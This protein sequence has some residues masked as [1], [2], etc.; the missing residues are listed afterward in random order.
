[1]AA[2]EEETQ[3]PSYAGMMAHYHEAFERE[4]REVVATAGV[5]PGERVVDV[6][7]GD[8]SYALWLAEQAGPDGEVLAVD[9]STPFLRVARR[10]IE[11][12]GSAPMSPVRFVQMDLARSPFEDGLADVAWCAQSLYSLPEPVEA[13]RRIA[14]LTREGGRIA[15][16]E[17]DELHHVNFPWP[18]ELDLALK[19]AELES[20]EARSDRPS[21]FYIARDLPS[22]FREAGLPRCDVR[23]F[24]FCRRPPFDD[25]TR[26][27]LTAHL[28]ELRKRT[29][30]Y[31]PEA[32]RAQVD[33]LADPRSPRFMLDD[34]DALVTCFEHLALSTRPGA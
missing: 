6:A 24:A 8:G 7:C 4:L 23:C 5:R 34:P 9:V 32:E 20:F 28:D 21:K 13:V 14:R 30:P 15:I 31:L 12:G 17:S 3:L 2:V 1:M 11:A 33:E 27:F 25:A 19:R 18:I 10:K 26:E 22:V 29:A 16:L